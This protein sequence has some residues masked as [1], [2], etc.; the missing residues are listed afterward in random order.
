MKY[1]REWNKKHPH[2]GRDKSRIR[3][4]S[5]EYVRVCPVCGKEFKTCIKHKITCSTQCE[6]KRKNQYHNL[7]QRG[8]YHGDDIQLLELFYRD[9]GICHICGGM[10]DFDDY[11]YKDGYFVAGNSY[12]SVDHIKPISK[13]GAHEWGNVKLAH[14]VCNAKRG[15]REWQNTKA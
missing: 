5:E 13:G 8:V 4:G 9:E 12:P 14:R 7:R 10:C 1:Q 2:Y 3:R 11:E 15:N 6:K